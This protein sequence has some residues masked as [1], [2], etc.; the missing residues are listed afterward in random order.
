MLDFYHTV[1]L[2]DNSGSIRYR[3]E[4]LFLHRLHIGDHP[5]RAAFVAK[6]EYQYTAHFLSPNV[7]QVR[8]PG[9]VM[10]VCL[11]RECSERHPGASPRELPQ[12][13]SGM[14]R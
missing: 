11:N 2:A 7:I 8:F 1:W 14:V 4:V 10:N 9:S 12:E 6:S 13:R 5:I 3:D